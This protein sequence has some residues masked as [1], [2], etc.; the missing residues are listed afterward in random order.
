MDEVCRGGGAWG[1]GGEEGVGR[2]S[3]GGVTGERPRYGVVG[4]ERGL[5]GFRRVHQIESKFAVM[6]AL[7][8]HSL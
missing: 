5:E 2:A 1:E 6:K 7:H 3:N 4:K 8:E